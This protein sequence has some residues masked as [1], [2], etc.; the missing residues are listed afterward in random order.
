MFHI[1]VN[2]CKL[3]LLM[4]LISVEINSRNEVGS[5]MSFLRGVDKRLTVCW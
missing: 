1:L 4:S 2:D 5:K 3:L